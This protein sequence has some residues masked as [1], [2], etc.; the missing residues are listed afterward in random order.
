MDVF[1]NIYQHGGNGIPLK[2]GDCLAN[3]DLQLPAM[4]VFYLDYTCKWTTARQDI[5]TLFQEGYRLF[6]PR[7]VIVH[8]TLSKMFDKKSEYEDT[9]TKILR[10]IMTLGEKYGY[11]VS[12]TRAPYASAKMF[13]IGVL[14]FKKEDN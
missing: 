9:M 11:H 8:L 3:K 10:Y 4:D 14:V 5:D 13:K 2:V 1:R 6:R 7:G 12:S